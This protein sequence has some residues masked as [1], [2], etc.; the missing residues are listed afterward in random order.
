MLLPQQNASDQARLASYFCNALQPVFHT[1]WLVFAKKWNT[2][3]ATSHGPAYPV[4]LRR[5][6][7]KLRALFNP[8]MP[9]SNCTLFCDHL[10]KVPI[11]AAAVKLAPVCKWHRLNYTCGH[12]GELYA[13]WQ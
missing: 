11:Q 5:P 3:L 2:L 8:E 13:E 10:C 7:W 9:S 4:C 12:A 6:L 1:T